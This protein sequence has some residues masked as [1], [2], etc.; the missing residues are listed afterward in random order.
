M[1]YFSLFKLCFEIQAQYIF[2]SLTYKTLTASF[3]LFFFKLSPVIFCWGLIYSFLVTFTC[4]RPHFWYFW[5]TFYEFFI[6]LWFSATVAAYWKHLLSWLKVF[7]GPFYEIRRIY[8][9][10]TTFEIYF[11]TS[12]MQQINTIEYKISDVS[13][14]IR[15]LLRSDSKVLW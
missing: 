12:E 11:T 2:I 7:I 8:I 6:S 5:R 3:G 14:P 4:K 9:W 15:Y 1:I 10:S 13:K